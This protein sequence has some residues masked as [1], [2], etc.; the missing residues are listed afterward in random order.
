MRIIDAEDSVFFKTLIGYYYDAQNYNELKGLLRK[1]L[2]I[3]GVL[4]VMML[5]AL[6]NLGISGCCG[7]SVPSVLESG[8]HMAFYCCGRIYG[9]CDNGSLFDGKTKEISVLSA[10]ENVKGLQCSFFVKN[11]IEYRV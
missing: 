1:T 3:I 6:T 8:W 10:K 7:I 2:I 9:G 11:M 5:V 4:I